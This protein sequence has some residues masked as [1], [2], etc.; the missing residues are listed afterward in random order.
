MLR[1][2]ARAIVLRYP[3]AWRERYEDEVLALIEDSPLRVRDLGELVRGLIVERVRALIEDADHPART[4]KILGL[5]Q[6]MFVIVFMA[7]AGG[8]GLVLRGWLGAPADVVPLIGAVLTLTFTVAGIGAKRMFLPRDR[9]GSC[10]PALPAWIGLTLLP[11]F[12]AGVVLS[13][14]AGWASYNSSTAMGW[15]R[16]FAWAWLYGTLAAELSS[17][18]WPGRRMLEVLGRLSVADAN[19][20]SAQQWVDGCHTMIAKGV[21]S[22]LDQALAHLDKLTKDRDQVR[23]ELQQLGYRARFAPEPRST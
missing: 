14:W 6:P 18:F 4:A 3:A 11:V 16:L 22:P 7:M 1:R 20:K 5:I 12:F 19:A 8:A 9:R 2:W 21:P 23:E 10:H 17:A 15:L 13:T